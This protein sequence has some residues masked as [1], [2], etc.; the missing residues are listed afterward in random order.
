MRLPNT[1]F[2]ARPWRVHEFTQ[3]FDVEDVWALDTPGGPDGLA[4]LVERLGGDG[5]GFHPSRIYRV[6][7]AIRWRLGALL[8]WDRD[9]QSV[10]ARY[11]SL[12]DRLPEDLRAGTRGPDLQVVPMKSVYQTSDEWLAELGNRT[13]HAAMHIGWVRAD[14][15]GYSA[16]MAVLVKKTGWL[17]RA[18][19]LLILPLR[20]IFVTPNLV[21]TISRQWPAAHP[22]STGHEG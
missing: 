16:Q 10:G 14:H 8:G 12:R 1:A 3:D 15:G 20:R 22:E 9:E 17:G 6:L 13:V 2:T 18:Y 7:F 4:V 19:M 5:R 21:K 11:G